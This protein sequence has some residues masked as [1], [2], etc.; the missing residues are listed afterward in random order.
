MSSPLNLD[1][2]FA[3]LRRATSDAFDLCISDRTCYWTVHSCYVHCDVSCYS[4]A[5]QLN[6]INGLGIIDGNFHLNF[7]THTL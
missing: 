6:L 5:E 2:S 7:T 1:I 3:S 4:P